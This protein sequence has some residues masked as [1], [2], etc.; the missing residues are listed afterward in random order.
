MNQPLDLRS[1]WK[2]TLTPTLDMQ[3]KVLLTRSGQ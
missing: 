1:V 2:S 3:R